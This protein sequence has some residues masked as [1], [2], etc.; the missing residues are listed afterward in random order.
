MSRRYTSDQRLA[1]AFGFATVAN[2]QDWLRGRLVRPYFDFYEKATKDLRAGREGKKG[3]E[4][5]S[6]ERLIASGESGGKQRYSRDILED[7]DMA[8]WS[9]EDYQAR[10]IHKLTVINTNNFRGPFF[11]KNLPQSNKMSIMWDLFLR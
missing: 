1:D 7:A 2:F 5:K 9:L 4:F 8:E 3:A 10:L 11:G 6:I